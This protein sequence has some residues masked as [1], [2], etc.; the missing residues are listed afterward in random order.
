MMT[1]YLQSFGAG[2]AR[3]VLALLVVVAACGSDPEGPDIDI[4]EAFVGNWNSTSFMVDGVDLMGAGSSFF[5]SFGFFSDGSY[6]LIVG[7]DD[8]FVICDIASSC[9]EDGDFSFT[10]TVLTIDPG[11]VDQLALQYSVSGDTLT[12]SG[13][14]DG[15][16][17]TAT[18]VRN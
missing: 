9:N 5:V 1:R 18:F 7:G 2:M 10:G 8:N 12:L 3:S 13:N 16:P 14:L 17:F 6:Q 4:D 11:T 15:T